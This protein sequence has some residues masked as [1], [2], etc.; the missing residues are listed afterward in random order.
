MVR[1]A[2][3]LE[4]L[5]CY[6]SVKYFVANEED[7]RMV[8]PT[9]KEIFHRNFVE[10]KLEILP[11]YINNFVKED[12]GNRIVTI[13]KLLKIWYFAANC[14]EYVSE[15]NWHEIFIFIDKYFEGVKDKEEFCVSC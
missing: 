2:N 1:N 4:S 8:L 12:L 5:F 13:D 15:E 14:S 6:Y 3:A 7:Y 11:E 9:L 10:E